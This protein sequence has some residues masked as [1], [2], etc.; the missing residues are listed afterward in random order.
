MMISFLILI[1]QKKDGLHK[2]E[3]HVFKVCVSGI[4]N[5]KLTFKEEKCEANSICSIN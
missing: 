4:K 5:R 2:V 3:F 1:F